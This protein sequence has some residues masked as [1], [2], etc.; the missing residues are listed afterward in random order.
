VLLFLEKSN[1]YERLQVY[2]EGDSFRYF[3]ANLVVENQSMVLLPNEGDRMS[4]PNVFDIIE[5]EKKLHSDDFET[6]NI[7]IMQ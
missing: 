1:H 2:Q 4:C 5:K 6:P 3:L 7:L